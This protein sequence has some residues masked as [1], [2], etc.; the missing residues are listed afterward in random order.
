MRFP[1]FETADAFPSGGRHIT[2]AL[3]V[4]EHKKSSTLL[5]YNLQFFAEGDGGE[6]TEEATPKK[7][8]DARKEGQVAKSQELNTAFEL[9]VLFVILKVFTG[10]LSQRFTDTFRLFYNSIETYSEDQF[11][12]N[13]FAA[14]F[15]SAVGQILLALLPILAA[16]VA[17]AIMVNALQVGWKPTGK[18]LQ[19]KFDKLNPINGFK[20]MFKLDK[21]VDLLKAILKVGLVGYIAYSTFIDQMGVVNVV[22]DLTL[23][24]AVMYVGDIVINFGL[25]VSIVFLVIG[26]A[27]FMYQKYKFAKEMRMSK[28]E[29]KDEFK[30]TE[31]DPKIKGQIRQKMREASQ[32]RMMQK[33][34]EADVV[35]TNP[36]HLAC[37]IKYDK[38][39]AEAPIL[40]AK[41]ADFLAEKIKEVARENFI[42]I[43]ENKPLARMLYH[44]VELDEEIPEELYQMTAEVLSYVYSINGKM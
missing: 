10:M 24:G 2:E 14:Y 43:V 40:L 26:V 13:Y 44:N 37:A 11:T 1:I 18:P 25:K 29:I 38:S 41:G 32:R 9:I 20:R 33:L 3:S 22:Y 35:I 12:M 4:D 30:Q 8:D 42:P 21:L 23:F 15:R 28:Q 19:P 6:K 7:L 27:D 36:T 34:P 31:G 39:I 5:K 16:S 17:V